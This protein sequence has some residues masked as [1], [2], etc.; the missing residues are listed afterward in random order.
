MP[1]T[2][3]LWN[4]WEAL[5]FNLMRIASP[6]WN[7]QYTFI[8]CII[9]LLTTLQLCRFI[10]N[11]Y[12]AYDWNSRVAVVWIAILDAI[13]EFPGSSWTQYIVS[14]VL[15]CFFYL[16][17]LISSATHKYLRWNVPV[18]FLSY[19]LKWIPSFLF[20]PLILPQLKMVFPCFSYSRE[21]YTVH[22][23]FDD[24]TCW[25]F[26][27]IGLS[28]LSFVLMSTFIAISFAITLVFYNSQIPKAEQ[29]RDN[30][31]CARV[32]NYP[33]AYLILAKS[34]ALILFIASNSD[35][36]RIALSIILTLT[37]LGL[38]YLNALTLPF[39][40]DAAQSMYILQ[41]MLC[42]WTG[43]IAFLTTVLN[44]T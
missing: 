34:L 11:A 6:D 18:Y 31:M 20:M 44:G 5:F 29:Y 13:S 42:A 32:N 12:I 38:V 23:F 26:S 33:E 28:I 15:I 9:W 35:S 19:L 43:V 10:S 2:T 24:L 22:P 41:G 30:A 16:W 4:K 21:S 14:V 37:G 3:L 7:A 8:Y 36:W 17:M 40:D 39:W 25:E 1:Y 27:H